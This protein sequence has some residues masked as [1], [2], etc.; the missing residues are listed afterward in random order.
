MKINYKTVSPRGAGIFARGRTGGPAFTLIELLVVIA[1]IAI[2]AAMLLPALAAAKHKA[3][4]IQCRGNL[5]QLQ[6]GWIMYA[7]ENNGEIPQNIASQCS[8]FTE[9]PLLPDAQPGRY[10]ASWVL[11]SA[12]APPYWTNSDLIVHGLIYQYVGNVEAYKCPEDTFPDRDRSY[13]MNCWMNGIAGVDASGNPI[14]WN[15]SCIN[16]TLLTDLQHKMPLGAFVFIDEN[17]ATV[18]DGFFAENPADPTMWVDAPAHYHNQGGDLSFYDGHV[19]HRKWSDAGVLSG[20]NGGSSGFKANP[21]PSPDLSWLQAI[22]T[23]VR[24]RGR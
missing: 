5:R 17:Y 20:L 14:A 2:I 24:P 13:S 18:N 10:R 3:K 11:G 12:D 1:I 4:D 9:D 7:D 19:E 8:W 23:T 6:M 16:F 21:Y 22:T 15:T